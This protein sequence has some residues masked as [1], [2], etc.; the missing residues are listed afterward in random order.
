MRTPRMIDDLR[1]MELWYSWISDDE[2]AA[3]MDHSRGVLRRRAKRLGLK[4]RREIRAMKE[5][6]SM[7]HGNLAG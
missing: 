3:L 6:F 4:P 2:M 7:L 1:L 5:A